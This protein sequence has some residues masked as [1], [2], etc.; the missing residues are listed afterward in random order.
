MCFLQVERAH[1]DARGFMSCNCKRLL[2]LPYVEEI[3]VGK[4]IIYFGKFT[5][6][7]FVS[8]VL[9]VLWNSLFAIRV[10]ILKQKSLLLQ[11]N[12][13]FTF[14]LYV[15]RT[16]TRTYK[17]KRINYAFRQFVNICI[18]T[19]TKQNNYFPFSTVQGG[20]CFY[21]RFISLS[22]QNECLK[23]AREKNMLLYWYIHF[24][25]HARTTILLVLGSGEN[26]LLIAVLILHVYYTI[27][28]II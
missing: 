5:L 4:N 6:G 7:H 21:L 27:F 25:I 19:K 12:P 18:F 22:S 26:S 17:R 23:F 9:P 10:F 24:K 20:C 13:I 16:R 2:P 28:Y 3:S 8:K 1:I 15:F 11:F 14:V